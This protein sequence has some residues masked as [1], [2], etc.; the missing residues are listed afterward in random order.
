M[1]GVA[2]MCYVA[3]IPTLVTL[4]IGGALAILLVAFGILKPHRWKR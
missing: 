3:S 1:G 2:L 4:E